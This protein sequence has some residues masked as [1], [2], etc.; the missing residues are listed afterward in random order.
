MKYLIVTFSNGTKYQIPASVIAEDR[1]QYYTDEQDGI[2][3][4]EEV[5]HTLQNPRLIRDWASNNMDWEDVKE[6][7]KLVTS[8]NIDKDAEWVNA[9]KDIIEP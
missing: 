4:E 6:E 8:E 5:E 1:A 7:A 9:K 2:N 3:F